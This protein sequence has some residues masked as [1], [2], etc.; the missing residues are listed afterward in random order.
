MLE[1]KHQCGQKLR[2][3]QA[4]VGK[5]VRCPKCGEPFVVPPQQG[6]S[7]KPASVPEVAQLASG[8]LSPGPPD[9][10]EIPDLESLLEGEHEAQAEPQDVTK[11][12]RQT[13]PI[14]ADVHR[15]LD[16]SGLNQ[17][18][19]LLVK[20]ILSLMSWGGFW[21]WYHT[22][23]TCRTFL[24]LSFFFVMQVPSLTLRKRLR[25]IRRHARENPPPVRVPSLDEFRDI[26]RDALQ[27]RYI[28]QKEKS[29]PEA[30]QRMLTEYWTS[31]KDAPT[32]MD[33]PSPADLRGLANEYAEI[34]RIWQQWEEDPR[35]G[36]RMM[37]EFYVA[38]RDR[39]WKSLIAIVD[40][41]LDSLDNGKRRC[42][43]CGK[44]GCPL[45]MQF[46]NLEEVAQP[47]WVTEDLGIWKVRDQAHWIMRRH[48]MGYSYEPR[49]TLIHRI[50]AE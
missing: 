39:L 32:A 4:L 29:D 22:C 10:S 26:A 35:V 12:M 1:F 31:S 9:E 5:R 37:K 27:I 23:P 18:I 6:I 16:G 38:K 20:S 46:H 43:K 24:G 13:S 19:A 15:P 47:I 30:A 8:P 34:C 40:R 2:A 45:C 42:V 11:P 7:S 21:F 33:P 44:Y 3:P 14:V 36:E 41:T 28:L 17:A 50:C 48:F 49:Y 25:E